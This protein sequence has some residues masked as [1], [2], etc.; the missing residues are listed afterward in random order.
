MLLPNSV[1]PALAHFSG[2]PGQF[3]EDLPESTQELV[4]AQTKQYYNRF[5]PLEGWSSYHPY[6]NQYPQYHIY[7]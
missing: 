1:V 7:I 6:D 5:Q 2:S 4:E 3:I